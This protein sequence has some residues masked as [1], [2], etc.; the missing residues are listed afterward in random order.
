[1]CSISHCTVSAA[2]RV[3][4]LVVATLL[5]SSCTVPEPPAEPSWPDVQGLPRAEDLDPTDDI[6]EY[7]LNIGEA[8]IELVEGKFVDGWTYNG[9]SP[10]PLLEAWVGQTMRIHVTNNLDEPTTVHW[11]GLRIDVAM[12]GVVL[13]KVQPINPGEW[14]VH[15]HILEHAELGMMTT[16]TVEP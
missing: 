15:C 3:V 10:G 7:A 16:V 9:T 13:G 1:M 4:L 14:M 8:T 6:A 11:H 5:L 2:N 12:D